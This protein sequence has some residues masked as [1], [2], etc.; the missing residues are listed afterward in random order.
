[1]IPSIHSITVERG[2][3]C[4]VWIEEAFQIEEEGAFNKLDMSIRGDMEE[5]YFKQLTLTFNPYSSQHWLKE[6]FF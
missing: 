3:L 2:Y 6:R 5:G 1:M 4:W